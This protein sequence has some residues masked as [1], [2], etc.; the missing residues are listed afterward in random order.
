MRGR[1]PFSSFKYFSSWASWYDSQV[2]H[3]LTRI[4][5]D[6]TCVTQHENLRT[7]IKCISV[8]N[9][10]NFC[11]IME[12]NSLYCCLS[13][14]KILYSGCLAPS[15]S[16]HAVVDCIVTTD[17]RWVHHRTPETKS[18]SM[19]WEGPRFPRSKD[20]NLMTSACKRMG[21]VCSDH[22]VALLADLCYKKQQ[23]M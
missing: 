19:G 10:T 16:R 5:N 21:N 3:Y 4:A 18:A 17:E 2:S 23:W 13:S 7:L 15:N 1:N 22:K 9:E 11:I 14:G 12:E 6:C 8:P 20:I